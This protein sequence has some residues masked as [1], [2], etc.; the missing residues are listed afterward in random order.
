MARRRQVD[1]AGTVARPGVRVKRLHDCEA[2]LIPTRPTRGGWRCWCGRW[3]EVAGHHWV[4]DADGPPGFGHFVNR[5]R[6]VTWLRLVLDEYRRSRELRAAA[7]YIDQPTQVLMLPPGG[8]EH[9][10]EAQ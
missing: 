1:A 5:W 9:R 2:P 10:T 6:R 4:L 8:F 3:W 7:P